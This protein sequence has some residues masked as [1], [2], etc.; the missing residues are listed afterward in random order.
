MDTEEK[1]P[2]GGK[3]I[4]QLHSQV[5]HLQR[6]L[7]AAQDERDGARADKTCLAAWL[8]KHYPEAFRDYFTGQKT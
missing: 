4:E 2:R 8:K 5:A 3:T 7:K 1:G 6:D